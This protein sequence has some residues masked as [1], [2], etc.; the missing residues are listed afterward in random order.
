MD[1]G[2]SLGKVISETTTGDREA[3]LEYGFH[4]LFIYCNIVQH[5]YVRHAL[6]P[7]FRIV[8]IEGKD[9][10]RVS[11]SSVRPQYVPVGRKQ[12]ETSEVNIMRDKGELVPFE[13]VR[14]LLTLHFRQSTP[15]FF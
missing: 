15:T 3:D 9:D 11:K 6:V 4:H 8:P 2:F 7:L 14:M 1:I 13:V 12:F 5:Q 10:Q